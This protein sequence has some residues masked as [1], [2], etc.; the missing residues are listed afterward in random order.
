V[1]K[2][3]YDLL[4]EISADELYDGLLGYGF[5][6]EK[7]PP[8]FTTVQFLDYCKPNK[9]FKKKKAL[10]SNDYDYIVFSSVRNINVPRI[11]GIP[12]PFQYANLCADLRDDWKELLK[13]F[14]D[15]TAGQSY[16]TKFQSKQQG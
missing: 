13:H 3:Y 10:R 9:T 14:E 16:Y 7:L 5:F 4:N 8:V 11:M 6:A 12:T 15:N 2:S 1:S